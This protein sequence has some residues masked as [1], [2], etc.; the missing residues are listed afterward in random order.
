MSTKDSSGWVD[1]TT[2]VGYKAFLSFSSSSDSHYFFLA[3]S[4][5]L[6]EILKFKI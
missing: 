2:Y 3:K 6:L 5:N 1:K 4:V